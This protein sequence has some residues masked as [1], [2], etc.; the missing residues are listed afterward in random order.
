MPSSTSPPQAS[1]DGFMNEIY[2]VVCRCT[3]QKL[4]RRW[5]TSHADFVLD[6]TR[7]QAEPMNETPSQ[8]SKPLQRRRRRSIIVAPIASFWAGLQSETCEWICRL[9]LALKCVIRVCEGG[10]SDWAWGLGFFVDLEGNM[11][12]I[13]CVCVCVVEGL[14]VRLGGRSP[15]RGQIPAWSFVFLSLTKF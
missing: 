6:Q 9:V 7:G 12:W 11:V 14:D 3:T 15:R 1:S 10:R 13:V 4:Q 2:G 5:A 8:A